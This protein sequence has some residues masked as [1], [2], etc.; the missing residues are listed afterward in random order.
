L[1]DR[2][3]RLVRAVDKFVAD[4]KEKQMAG[5]VVLLDEKNEAN[6]KKLTDLAAAEGLSIP[7][8][9]ALEGP[10][11]PKDYKLNP[12]V[13][14]TVLVSRKDIVWGNYVLTDPAPKDEA[15]QEKQFAPIF[16]KAKA[17]LARK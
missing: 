16:A 11:G 2:L 8:T 1:D 3:T 9:I 17:V 14:L 12:R 5:F 13:P 10:K 6:E 4:N 15:A 7:L